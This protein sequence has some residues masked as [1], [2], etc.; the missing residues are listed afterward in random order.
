MTTIKAMETLIQQEKPAEVEFSPIVTVKVGSS[1]TQIEN[2]SLAET[3]VRAYNLKREIDALTPAYDEARGQIINVARTFLDEHGT[4][5]FEVKTPLGVISV[6]VTF[7]YEAVIDP[8]NI[9]AVKEV[10]K[11]QFKALV[12]TKVK[13]VATKRLMEIL[14]SADEPLAELLRPYIA[15]K[16]FGR[17]VQ[18]KLK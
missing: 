13:Y 16:E 17:S 2:S 8:E 6:K 10:L 4:V 11:D 12:R 15:V 3:I 7:Q 18:F 14:C 9:N 5:N 1:K